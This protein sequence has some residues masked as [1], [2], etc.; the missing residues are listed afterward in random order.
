MGS[1][2]SSAY[3]DIQNA[4]QESQSFNRREAGDCHGILRL[5]SAPA[6][7]RPT[8][9]RTIISIYELSLFPLSFFDDQ[10]YPRVTTK[11]ALLRVLEKMNAAVSTASQPPSSSRVLVLDGMAILQQHPVSGS[12]IFKELV[13]SFLQRVARLGVG[14][15]ELHLVFDR[16]DIGASLKDK[17][18]EHRTRGGGY[19]MDIQVASRIEAGMTMARIL[20]TKSNKTAMVSLIASQIH[21]HSWGLHVVCAW[22]DKAIAT[23]GPDGGKFASE[24]EEADTKMIYHLS[25]LDKDVEATVVSPDTDV[26]VFLL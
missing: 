23:S 26:L 25:L 5:H 19:D 24:Q 8:R 2:V 14:Y 7:L 22:R 21:H 17:T 13:G 11:S 12:A 18:K 15:G 6:A 3:Q 16:Y 9:L 10:G 4:E 20:S 1:P